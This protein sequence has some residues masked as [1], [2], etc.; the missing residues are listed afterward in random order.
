MLKEPGEG[1]HGSFMQDLE[2]NVDKS[3]NL[4]ESVKGLECTV[5]SKTQQCSHQLTEIFIY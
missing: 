3:Q 2:E 1:L 4:V 5:G